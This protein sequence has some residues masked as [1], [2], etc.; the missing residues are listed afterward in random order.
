LVDRGSS[1]VHE[2]LKSLNEDRAFPEKDAVA[3]EVEEPLDV[4]VKAPAEDPLVKGLERNED[5]RDGRLRTRSADNQ[6][7]HEDS[8]G[9][10]PKG[11]AVRC[12]SHPHRRLRSREAKVGPRSYRRYARSRGQSNGERSRFRSRAAVLVRGDRRSSDCQ[13]PANPRTFSSPTV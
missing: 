13:N 4:V 6:Q 11:R 8:R 9:Q 3:Y 1:L 12:P 10:E 2:I 5:R 7:A